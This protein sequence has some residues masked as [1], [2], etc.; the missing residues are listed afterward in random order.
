MAIPYLHL[1]GNIFSEI[2]WDRSGN[3]LRT[4]IISGAALQCLFPKKQVTGIFTVSDKIFRAKYTCLP[5]C[6]N[7]T[8]EHFTNWFH[9]IIEQ[10]ILLKVYFFRWKT[11][12]FKKPD[13]EKGYDREWKF[14]FI[15]FFY[16]TTPLII[17]H[18][19]SLNVA[20]INQR[21]LYL[22][23]IDISNVLYVYQLQ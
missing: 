6:L 4:Q 5:C 14:L 7:Q 12:L 20:I 15:T 22:F 16:E 23:I 9:D 21:I 2:W 18:I 17:I 11:S 19:Y 8:K 1:P 13:F 10:V 3:Y